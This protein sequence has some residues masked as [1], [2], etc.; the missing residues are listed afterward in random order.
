MNTLSTFDKIY[1]ENYNAMFRI[2][3][4]MVSDTD[5]VSDIVQEIF[6]Y[7]Y[8]KLKNGHAIENHKAWLYRATYN[9]CIDYYRKHKHFKQNISV[10]DCE[11]EEEPSVKDE[12]KAVVQRALSGLKTKEKMLVVLYSEGL[13]YKE[14]SATTGIKFSSVGK[15]LSRTLT[16]LQNELKKS[17]NELY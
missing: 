14:I 9:K 12:M 6:I 16:K 7:F 13:S 17:E 3:K 10:E 15:M 1:K 5:D 11:I 4:K 2:A 8:D